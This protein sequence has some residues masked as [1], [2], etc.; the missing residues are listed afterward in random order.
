MDENTL[1]VDPMAVIAL[2]VQAVK[3][4]NAKVAELESKCVVY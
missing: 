2:L 1:A 4:L 3:E